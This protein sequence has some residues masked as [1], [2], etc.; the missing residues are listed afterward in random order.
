MELEIEELYLG[1]ASGE[2]THFSELSKFLGHLPRGWLI[3]HGSVILYRD[4]RMT[5]IINYY[6]PLPIFIFLVQYR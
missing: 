5:L 3:L 6:I 1:P 4:N 2:H